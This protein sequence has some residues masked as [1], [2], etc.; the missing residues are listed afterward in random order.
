MAWDDRLLDN[1]S[2]MYKDMSGKLEV[3]L[4]ELFI[5]SDFLEEAVAFIRVTGFNSGSVVVNFRLSWMP[6]SDPNFSV[7]RNS[8]MTQ[9]QR[10][11]ILDDYRLAG[12]YTVKQNSLSLKCNTIIFIS[13]NNICPNV[14]VLYYSPGGCL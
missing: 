4:D 11:L 2:D 3:A 14:F 12:I 8:L 1:N 13:F 10:E 6:R 5:T 9:F 7:S